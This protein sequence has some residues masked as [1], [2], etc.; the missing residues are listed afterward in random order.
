VLGIEYSRMTAEEIST[1][2]NRCESMV[3][4]IYSRSWT[5]RVNSDRVLLCQ[6]FLAYI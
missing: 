4:K 6:A 2:M 5:F 1:G 3:R